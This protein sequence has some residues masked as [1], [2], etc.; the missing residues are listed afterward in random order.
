MTM[1][2]NIGF[3]GKT[4]R[5]IADEI[6]QLF[7]KDLYECFYE[8]FYELA[9][10]CMELAVSKEVYAKYRPMEYVRRKNKGGLTDPKNFDIQIYQ[11]TNGNIVG[12]VRNTARG[13]GR[14]FELDEVIVSGMGYDWE[15]SKIYKMQPFPRDF[16]S[17]TI[18]RIESSRWKYHVRRL[19]NKRGWHT[20]GK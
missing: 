2:R 18:D 14:A 3:D 9:G 19:M 4:S 16:Y 12:Y 20:V 6:N 8:V 13:V 7:L 11:Q 17:A 5:Q 15:D 1:K 10:E